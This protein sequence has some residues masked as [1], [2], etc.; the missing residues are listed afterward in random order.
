MR[1]SDLQRG[2]RL[3]Q[4]PVT[5]FETRVVLADIPYRL[6]FRFFPAA[7]SSPLVFGLVLTSIICDAPHATAV[8][9][10]EAEEI[11]DLVDDEGRVVGFSL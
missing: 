2:E 9:D 8:N 7:I 10:N 6:A 4:I 11:P 5:E 1:S 3:V